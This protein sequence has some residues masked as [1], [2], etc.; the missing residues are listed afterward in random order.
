MNASIAYCRPSLNFFHSPRPGFS[1]EAKRIEA[2]QS[3][4][5]E[6]FQKSLVLGGQCSL[7]R[8]ALIELFGETSFSNWDG[9]GAEAVSFETYCKA[10]SFLRLLPSGLK[11]PDLSAHPD[12]EIAF[13][14]RVPPRK[15][16]T[17]SVG[18]RSLI[19]YAGI[20][21]GTERHGVED[22]IDEIPPEI[23]GLFDKLRAE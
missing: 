14:W 19:T 8:D 6:Q 23:L 10:E 1:Q 4:L 15:I 20:F 18:P 9:Y 2:K 16:V 3:A 11:I 17:I 5:F 7:R 21:G 12:G 13:E 22:F